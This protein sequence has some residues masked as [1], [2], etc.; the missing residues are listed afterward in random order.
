MDKRVHGNDWSVTRFYENPEDISYQKDD[1]G[2]H[3]RYCGSMPPSETIR[4]LK[5]ADTKVSGSDWKYGWP[6]KFY[7]HPPKGWGK[8]Y[9]VHLYDA[10]EEEFKELADL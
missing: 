6:H 7:I 4:L 5:D 10:T 9:S 1:R 8:F 3:C 2:I